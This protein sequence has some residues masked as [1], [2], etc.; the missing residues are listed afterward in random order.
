M[1]SIDTETG[2]PQTVIINAAWGLGENVVQGTV[3]P[4][5]YRVFKPLLAKSA[6]R[7]IV[8]K[9]IGAKERKMVYAHGGTKSTKN[10]VTTVEEKQAFV[11]SDDEI[12][13]LA[14]WAKAIE[15]H[16]QRPMDMEWAKD[17]QSG[18]IFMVQAR[19]E[20]VQSRQG[21]ASLQHYTLK[22]RGEPVV[23]GLSIGDAP[24]T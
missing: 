23:S 6:Y 8:E 21:A 17:G 10:V 3:T 19:P 13:Q 14:R 9:N 12:L 16:Y 4:D 5:E 1:F 20:T 24:T 11:L 2:F 15:D 18:D 22:E 7:P